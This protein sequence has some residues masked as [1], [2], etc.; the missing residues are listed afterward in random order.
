MFAKI[1]EWL[2]GKVILKKVIGKF[3]KGG[4]STLAGLAGVSQFLTE[5]GIVV[6]WTKLETYLV[7]VI[8]GGIPAVINFFKHRVKK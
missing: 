4:L 8:G 1:K 3:V 7:A 5:A 6:D 2:F